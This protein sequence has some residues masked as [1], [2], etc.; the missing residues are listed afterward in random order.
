M[1][2]I[3]HLSD[4][5]LSPTEYDEPL[6]DYKIDVIPAADR[7][8]R[9]A[10]IRS[11]LRSL[12]QALTDRGTSLDALVIS[13]DITYR[14]AQ[15][16]FDLLRAT[17]AELGDA[18]P[19]SNRVLVVPGN[20]DVTWYSAPSSPERYRQ[21]VD[22][23]RS[24]GYRT[25][26]LEG[27]DILPDGEIAS[28]AAS[29]VIVTADGAV[30]IL[31]LNTTN[32]CGVEQRP[33]EETEAAIA[34]LKR[35]LG[36]ESPELVALL[37][38]WR[39]RGR[40]DIARLDPPQRRWASDF[41]RKEVAGLEA[42]PLRMA[43]MHHQ[44]LPVTTDEEIKPFESLTN[45]G[46]VREFFAAN[47]IDVLLHGHKHSA[48]VYEDR[49]K[50][51]GRPNG[52]ARTLLVC[53]TATVG[54]GQTRH[55]EVAK[56]LD[57]RADLPTIRRLSVTS[58]PCQGEGIPLRD[59]DLLPAQI[60][61]VGRGDLAA[62]VFAGASS[63][64]IHEQL[65]DALR[66]SAQDVTRPLICHI[67]FGDSALT[68]PSTYPEI[69][70]HTGKPQS[71]FD[72]M[73]NWWQ[74]DRAGRGMEF[75]HGERLRAYAGDIDQVDRVVAA[76]SSRNDSSRSVVVL[77]DPRKD[78]IGNPDARFPAFALAHF[79]VEEG[80]VHVT[81]YFRKQEMIYWWPIN[82]AELATLQKE[83][84]DRLASH[85]LR[86]A[87][88]SIVTVT[89]L[90]IIGHS[91]PRVSVPWI[92][93][94]ADDTPATL[95]RAAIPLVASE[96]PI[97][98]AAYDWW[99]EMF[100]DWRPAE[101]PAPDGD[102]APSFGLN[103]LATTIDQVAQIYDAV[104]DVEP[105]VDLLRYLALENERYLNS[106]RRGRPGAARSGWAKN[107]RER[108]DRLLRLVDERLGPLPKTGE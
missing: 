76:L 12:G 54:L 92:D 9:T 27:V 13:G 79:L 23:V 70:G 43:V 65:I 107:A 58:V 85:G 103:V 41:L 22:G 96:D 89:A 37:A 34:A 78:E 77:V 50:P 20:H 36:D 29:P 66:D 88:G 72:E 1:A 31:G 24:L 68:M 71:W 21:F 99:Q 40:F 42:P 11:S 7:V 33:S 5:H 38:D 14:G 100:L 45:L 2:L 102:P 25:P 94:I 93:R 97:R 101:D 91:I 6:G 39:R 17:L 69:P 104:S 75:N 64:D 73:V 84:L 74:R 19:E 30:A 83:V 15:D 4:L 61:V 57:V 48:G 49:Y 46:E 86:L 3:L 67:T 80:A 90:P 16:G 47:D 81:A 87:A 18:L 106:E 44:L 59:E 28:E 10:L 8:R 51:S 32:H 63:Q 35:Q 98:L 60:H 56:L 55:G 62:G 108:I 82:V 53:S 105:I 52:R 95:L 26:L